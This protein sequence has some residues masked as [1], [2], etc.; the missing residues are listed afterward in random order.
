MTPLIR[1]QEAG[2]IGIGCRKPD[3]EGTLRP[4]IIVIVFVE[5]EKYEI[6]RRLVVAGVDRY[7]KRI[8]QGIRSQE[9][10]F[11]CRNAGPSGRFV[12]FPHRIRDL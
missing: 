7:H 5:S 8:D 9:G 4:F 6:S 3:D 11:R 10:S 2:F 12:R 1:G